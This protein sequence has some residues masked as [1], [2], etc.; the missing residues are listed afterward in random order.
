MVVLAI[1]EAWL[2]R[3]LFDQYLFTEDKEYLKEIMPILEENVRFCLA[4]LQETDQGTCYLPR[5]TSPENLFYEDC[6]VA[7][8]SENT[9]AIVRN[10]FRDYVKGCEVLGL[11]NQIVC[12]VLEALGAWYLLRWEARGRFWSGTRNF[13]SRMCIIAM[14]PIFTSFILAAALLLR[15]QVYKAVRK[16][17]ELRGD[18]GTGW[19][20]A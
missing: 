14:F 18:E 12:D 15:H 20:L 4:Q 5:A 17:L 3:N 1:W 9:L 16:S 7:K 10:L 11:Q 13:R 8:Y 2:C 19:S 6:S